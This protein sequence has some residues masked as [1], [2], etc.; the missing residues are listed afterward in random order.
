M[1]YGL[2]C[3]SISEVKTVIRLGLEL[4]NLAQLCYV[5]IVT[6]YSLYFYKVRTISLSII[7]LSFNRYHALR[8]HSN[9]TLLAYSYVFFSH[10]ILSIVSE[11]FTSCEVTWLL[12][13]YSFTCLDFPEIHVVIH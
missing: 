9:S 1:S 4:C 2:F 7:V 12:I 6:T 13:V 5:Y 10:T 11:P 8:V 3:Q